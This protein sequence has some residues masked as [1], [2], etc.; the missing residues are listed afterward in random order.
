M[1]ALLVSGAARSASQTCFERLDAGGSENFPER[2]C[3]QRIAIVDEIES[4]L[5]E[6]FLGICEIA[7]DLLHP[8]SVRPLG[9]PRN[10][11]PASLEIDDEEHE[12]ADQAPTCEHLDEIVGLHI[13]REEG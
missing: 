6:S 12:V 4:S 2:R 10:L 1:L 8:I 5:Q 13:D 11:D 3:E 7:S 9:D